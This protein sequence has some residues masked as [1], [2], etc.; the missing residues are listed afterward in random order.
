M[1]ARRW[2]V[3]AWNLTMTNADALWLRAAALVVATAG[4]AG[5]EEK[6]A[7]AATAPPPGV[8]VAQPIQRDVISYEYF[9]GRTA[10]VDAVDVRSRVTGYLMKTGFREGQEVKTND[11]LFQV[12]PR[13]YQ[14]ELDRLL[15]QVKL[16]Q[17]RLQLAK[18]DLARAL[19]VAKTP[20]AISQQDIDKYASTVEEADASVAA[21][22]ANAEGARLNVE[23]T[24]VISPIDGVA[25]RYLVT[26]GNL[27]NQDQTLLTTVVSVD[28]MY[29]YFDVD[30]RTVLRMQESIRRGEMQSARQGGRIE[31][32]L[33][34]ATE[35]ESY[36]HAGAVDFAN[37]QISTTTGTLQARAAFPNPAPAA[38]APRLLTPGLFVRVRVPM[39]KP[40]PALLIPQS[41]LVT[42][43]GLKVLYVVDDKNT[44]EYRPV[45]VGATQPG[46]L[47]EVIAVPIVR[48][49]QGVRAAEPGEKG[50]PSITATDQVVISGLQRI[51]PGM[52]VTPQRE[53][54]K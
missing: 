8:T 15:G 20:G 22:K 9:T 54:I 49:P 30:E 38:G 35:G 33:G 11:V 1:A 7:P 4:L 42:D 14:A 24:D 3:V 26:P 50:E 18:A 21:A 51:R 46:G 37:N 41:A 47:Q 45:E 36:P 17:A 40:H 23:F 48:T 16:T 6:A 29:A 43:Q 27:V 25:G 5:C 32:D 13:P 34:L 53:Q 44:V 12:D 52:V 31:V 19:E 2:I 28:P 39:G 10:A